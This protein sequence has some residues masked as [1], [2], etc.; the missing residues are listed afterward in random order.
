MLK[1]LLVSNILELSI[2][3]EMD[4]TGRLVEYYLV[5]AELI[6]VSNRA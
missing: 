1:K 5:T 6:V 3:L 4:D 2:L